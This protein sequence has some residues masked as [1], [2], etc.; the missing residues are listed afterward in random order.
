MHCITKKTLKSTCRPC[1][2]IDPLHPHTQTQQRSKGTA[3][4]P[5]LH[6]SNHHPSRI[7]GMSQILNFKLDVWFTLQSTGQTTVVMQILYIQHIEEIFFN[8][9][10]ISLKTV[11]PSCHKRPS[12][13][14]MAV[15]S[16]E[17]KKK[18]G[19]LHDSNKKHVPKRKTNGF[20]PPLKEGLM[21]YIQ[22]CVFSTLPSHIKNQTRLGLYAGPRMTCQLQQHQTKRD[23][24]C[25][26]P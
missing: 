21:T 17:K 10:S 15:C 13:S 8:F 9:F 11:A 1:V 22:A 3:S 18:Q 23:G 6:A 4:W 14:D 26:R 25:I 5:S 12:R 19:S 16:K 2:D 7:A 24:L 20:L